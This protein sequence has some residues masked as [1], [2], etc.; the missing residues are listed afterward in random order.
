VSIRSTSAEEFHSNR[1]QRLNNERQNFLAIFLKPDE[2]ESRLANFADSSDGVR[3][4][5]PSKN[6]LRLKGEK[7]DCPKLV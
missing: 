4:H 6:R 7:F 3:W 2:A 1:E 5:K